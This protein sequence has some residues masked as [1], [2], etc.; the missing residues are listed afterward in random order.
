[1]V[2][3]CHLAPPALM[4]GFKRVQA[5]VEYPTH[6]LTRPTTF[7]FFHVRFQLFHPFLRSFYDLLAMLSTSMR[8][9][10]ISSLCW[11][12]RR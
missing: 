9:V 8:N 7:T 1:M 6:A 2:A 3:T 10:P 4:P 11:W 12:P 5:P